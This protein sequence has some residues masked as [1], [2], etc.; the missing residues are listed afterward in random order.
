MSF[1]WMRFY[2]FFVARLVD[3]QIDHQLLKRAMVKSALNPMLHLVAILFAFLNTKAAI[4][5]YVI[6]PIL[7]F[8]PSS[9]EKQAA[10]KTIEQ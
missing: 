7:F 5:M 3:D 10:I 9:L 4:S 2:A 1:S 8:F 6:I